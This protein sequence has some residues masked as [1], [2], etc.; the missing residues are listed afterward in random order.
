MAAKDL[1]LATVPTIY[2]DFLIDEQKRLYAIAEN[3][4]GELGEWDNDALRLEF[5]ELA[6]L[7]IRL[8]LNLEVS[9]FT[10]SEI[11]DL[12]IEPAVNESESEVTTFHP[13]VTREGDIWTL[14]KHRLLC[15]DA[16]EDAN[17]ER[18]L[19]GEK[20]QMAFVDAP[21]NQPMNAISGKGRDQHGEF[22]MASGELSREEFTKFLT[23]SSDTWRSTAS[24]VRSIRARVKPR[25]S[26][27]NH[28][29]DKRTSVD[30]G[31]TWTGP[32]EP[33]SSDAPQHA[34]R[35]RGKRR[36]SSYGSSRSR[37]VL[38]LRRRNPPVHPGSRSC[39]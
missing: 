18:L 9:G 5:G 39:Q 26:S 37:P 15:G 2:V 32:P 25:V 30:A 16:R 7:G 29:F 14:G 6:D 34:L 21:Y 38:V 1:G 24:T 22:A 3:R 12:L 35:V 23:T 20:A 33:R 11:D 8:D 10:M 36:S 13:P 4:S 27:L 19:N 28:A 31:S 17:C